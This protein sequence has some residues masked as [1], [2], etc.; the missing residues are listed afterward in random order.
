[1]LEFAEENAADGDGVGEAA[2]AGKK[3]DNGIEGGDGAEVYEG[4]NDGYG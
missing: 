1:M 2:R 3:T 4:E